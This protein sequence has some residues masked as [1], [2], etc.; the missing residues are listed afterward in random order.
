MV[1]AFDERRK[2]IVAGLNAIERLRC[3]TPGGAFYAFPNITGTGL[4]SAVMEA[5]LL[6]EAGVATVSGASFGELGEGYLRFSYANSPANIEEALTRI[7]KC[8]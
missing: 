4:S 6:T 5:K 3:I 7:R 8:L 1:A 2:A